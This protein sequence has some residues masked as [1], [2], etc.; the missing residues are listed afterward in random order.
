MLLP[1][2]LPSPHPLSDSRQIPS[3][4]EILSICFYQLINISSAKTTQPGGVV[5]PAADNFS[6]NLLAG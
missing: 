2:V 6:D 5:K 4:I 1:S 3:S